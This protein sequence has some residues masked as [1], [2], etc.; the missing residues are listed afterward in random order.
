MKTLHDVL[1]WLAESDAIATPET[2][3]TDKHLQEITTIGTLL[4]NIAFKQAA[5]R[6]AARPC[7]FVAFEITGERQELAWLKEYLRRVTETD[8]AATLNQHDTISGLPILSSADRL[9]ENDRIART[10]NRA[11]ER[12]LLAINL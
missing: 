6:M 1:L 2:Q 11:I 8:I 9:N 4:C 10:V 3:L 7:D 5:Q 12:L